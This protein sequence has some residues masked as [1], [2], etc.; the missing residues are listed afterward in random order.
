MVI[1]CIINTVKKYQAGNRTR[2]P[3]NSV[4]NALAFKLRGTHPFHHIAL[5]LYVFTNA[6]FI[7]I[8]YYATV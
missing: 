4:S 2:K 7:C 5:T 6:G 1:K 3:L 8:S